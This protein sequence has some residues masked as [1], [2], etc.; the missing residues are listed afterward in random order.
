MNFSKTSLVLPLLSPLLTLAF[1]PSARAWG[2]EGHQTVALLAE[3]HLTPQANQ[4]LSELLQNNPIDSNLPRFCGN[5]VADR[6]A[7]ASTWADDFRKLHT[8]TGPWHFLDIP[9]SVS[10]PNNLAQF[11]D[12]EGCVT[13]AIHDQVEI[14]KNKTKPAPDRADALRFIIH[15]VG[16]VH[17]P[18]HGVN[19]GGRGGNCVPVKLSNRGTFHCSTAQK[20]YTPNLHGVWD[21]DLVERGMEG[22]TPDQYAADL[23]AEFA[24]EISDWQS[25]G[26]DPLAWAWESHQ[27]AAETAYGALPK[28]IAF[29]PNIKVADC[30]QDNKIGKRMCVKH[31]RL[32]DTY[33]DTAVGVIE[34]RLAQAGIR[35]AMILNDAAK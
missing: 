16:D 25:A 12:T 35:L 24:S 28:N 31:L 8:E 7:D 21:K 19:N 15:F 17:Q 6:F 27:A 4:A 14:L 10:T 30:T 11:C 32:S 34:E 26:I 20:S 2:C 22:R 13:K 29:E 23:D 5:D 33:K 9:L 3:R 1:A 18:L